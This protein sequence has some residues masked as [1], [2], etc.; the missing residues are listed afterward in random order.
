MVPLLLVDDEPSNLESLSAILEQD[1]YDVITARNGQQALDRFRA[2]HARGRPVQLVLTDLRMPVMGGEELI[3][4]LAVEPSPPV[5]LIQS[6]VD[7][8]D[9]IIDLMKHGVYDYLVKPYSFGELL[10]RVDKAAE[11]VELCGIK[12]SV[13][14]ER[15]SRRERPT[16]IDGSG[17][18]RLLAQ[19]ERLHAA[20]VPGAGAYTIPD[21]AM[22]PAMT[23]VEGAHAVLQRIRA[24]EVEGDGSA[25]SEF[26][27]YGGIHEIVQSTATR[28]SWLAA[29]GAHR[30]IITDPPEESERDTFA[31]ERAPFTEAVTEVLVN[32]MKFSSPGSTVTVQW[33]VTPNR[34]LRIAFVSHPVPDAFGNRGILPEYSSIVFEPFYRLSTSVNADYGTPDLGLGLTLVDR[35]MDRHGGRPA[36]YNIAG[37]VADEPL[38]VVEMELKPIHAV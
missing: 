36:V 23:L 7:D 11:Y 1:G 38:V 4:R 15:K 13:E 5:V 31:V 18:G 6:V 37:D 3:A 25:V 20:A 26:L 12:S 32:A 24:L 21:L 2:E 22:R 10:H 17:A 28:V 16:N 27:T 34:R 9:H 29:I 8:V 14:R 35:V 33:T 30:L 19:L